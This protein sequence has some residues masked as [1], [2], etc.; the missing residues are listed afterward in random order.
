MMV[1]RSS[2]SLSLAWLAAC[3]S[4]EHNDSPDAPLVPDAAPDAGPGIDA[5]PRGTAQVTVLEPGGTGAPA[6]GASV[7]FL[8]PDGTLVKRTATDTSGKASA[9][10]LPG[11]S[12]TSVALLGASYQIQTVTAIRPG[13]DLVLGS[14][15]ARAVGTFSVTYP[16]STNTSA[17]AYL[18][19]SPCG[20]V[21]AFPDAMTTTTMTTSLTMS[22]SCVESSMEIVVMPED[23]SSVPLGT[24]SKAGVA[25]QDGGSTTITGAYLPVRSFTGSYTNIDP[26]IT[27]LSML[28]SVPDG[29]GVGTSDALAP[30]TATTVLHASG[31]VGSGARI[32]TH[33]ATTT[34]SIADVRQSISGMAATYGLDIGATL[35]PWLEQPTF[36]PATGKLTVPVDSTGTTTAAPDFFRVV[37]S[38][39]RTDASTTT[40]YTWTVFGPAPGDVTLPV[41]PVELG[42]I[43]PIASDTISSVSAQMIDADTL[44][45]YDDVRGD[46]NAAFTLYGGG[47]PPAATVRISG[48]PPNRIL[49]P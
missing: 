2:L 12:V 38:Y 5:T 30:P 21:T 25:F 14:K 8:D 23:A 3:G 48:S 37:L 45:G 49:L 18:V 44:A 31:A 16:T 43:A 29:F 22:D 39:R 42:P 11:A 24:I 1:R 10:V 36:D 15:P 13:D 19:A 33:A 17:T 41:L 20:T 7:V 9:D 46:L 28:R 47:R 6:V 4:V 26:G 32:A 27:S 35:L 40:G 34:R